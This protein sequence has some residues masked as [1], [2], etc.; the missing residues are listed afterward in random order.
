MPDLQLQENENIVDGKLKIVESFQVKPK[1]KHKDIYE[2]KFIVSESEKK[3][4]KKKLVL[5]PRIEAIH[6]G[7][8][9]NDNIY[10]AEKLKGDYKLKSG[11]YSFLQPY[12]KPVIKNHDTDSEP[13]GRVTNAQFITDSATGKEAVV[14]IPEITDPETIEKILDG[15]Y[16][17]V[18]IGATTD[19]AI[20][21]ICGKDIIK[22]GWCGH[23]R[24][25]EYDGV[26]CGWIVGNLWF[27]EVSFVN[28]PADSDAKVIDKGELTTMEAYIQVG[29]EYYNISS[30]TDETKLTEAQAKLLGL[31]E[32][33]E[34]DPFQS[35]GGSEKVSAKTVALGEHEKVVQEKEQLQSQLEEKAQEITELNTKLQEKE[36]LIK[37]KEELIVE[38]DKALEEKEN[39]LKEKEQKLEELNKDIEELKTKNESLEEENISLRTEMRKNLAETVVMLKEM[40]LKPID[41]DR[42][43]A[44]E[45]HLLRSEESLRDTLNDLRQEF[46]RVLTYG[47]TISNPVIGAVNG[48]NNQ[49]IEGITQEQE[50]SREEILK[51]LFSGRIK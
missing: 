10:P 51:N 11:V 37:E 50:L 30:E 45:E 33:A 36:Q 18:S 9:R 8:T 44:I 43:K 4:K 25:E 39:L 24:G 48:E 40:L 42:E 22:E 7:R 32:S 49:T 29:E 31:T 41:A 6:A 19:S 2:Q 47:T 12:P 3:D 16:L 5:K 1:I 28:V 20:C 34:Q 26:V 35:K 23:V 13:L 46:A 38:K 27:D 15:R 14:I 21:N 17:T